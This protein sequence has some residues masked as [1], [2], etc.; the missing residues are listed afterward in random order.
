MDGRTAGLGSREIQRHPNHCCSSRKGVASRFHSREL[1]SYLFIYIALHI[2]KQLHPD[3][4]K[5]ATIHK[6]P[7]VKLHVRKAV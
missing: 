3:L 1:V 6:S 5:P 4:V 2:S 7:T